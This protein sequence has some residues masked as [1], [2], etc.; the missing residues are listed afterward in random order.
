MKIGHPRQ[1]ASSDDWDFAGV[2]LLESCGQAALVLDRSGTIIYAN[3]AVERLQRRPTAEIVGRQIGLVS[4]AGQA[5]QAVDEQSDVWKSILAGEHWSGDIWVNR[6]DGSRVPAYATRSPL[7]GRDGDVVGVLSLAT[8][9]TTE[10]EAKAALVASE[11]RFRALFARSSD[12][13]IL[14]DPDGTMSY[15]SPSLEAVSGLR[16][17]QLLGSSA[18]THVHPDDQQEL[19][20]AVAQ[21]LGPD[22][23]VTGEWRMITAGGWRWFEM[24]LSDM[25]DDPAVG[26]IVGNLRD[27][28]ERREAL[29]SLR[30]LAERFRRVFDESP[31]GKMIV[32][33][34]LRVVEVNQALCENLGYPAGELS[35]A[36]IDLL[37]H[38]S[39]VDEQRAHW[40]A[41]F[42]GETDRFQAHLRYR[43]ADGTEVVARVSAAGLHDER[44]QAL[45]GI[46]EVE[47]AT[48][49][50]RASEELA[51]R[52]LTDPL[53][54]LPNRA[55]LQ[56]RLS[57]A[58]AR[59][60][61][62]TTLLAVMFLDVDRFKLVND[63]FGHDAGDKLLVAIAS[64]LSAAVRSTDTVARFGGDE[65]VV[66]LEHLGDVPN[67]RAFGERLVAAVAAPVRLDTGEV[68]PSVSIGIAC[69]SDS[70]SNPG[71]LLRDAD[72]A[73]YRAKG[74]GGGRCEL[75]DRSSRSGRD[76]PVSV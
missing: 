34:D 22:Q 35:G 72:L 3:A 66:V 69:T 67:V 20:D 15:L 1:S 19:M 30:T 61:R 24:T 58:L 36:S 2:D 75:S 64:R 43:R 48:E 37:V 10:H 38:P 23:P 31:V 45:S 74:A 76:A 4:T 42:G 29:E 46:C 11:R 26:G 52:A 13:A 51:R 65:F 59:L 6:G 25:I 40:A 32:D 50:V 47:D 27:V 63:G 49:Q 16:P 73:M 8:D 33:T 68:S 55:L 21:R 7:F 41:L 56:D 9:R 53:T 70:A 57:Q 71:W 44:G 28:T 14:F 39:E 54:R 17:D 60:S 5:G 62:E 12:L 18:W